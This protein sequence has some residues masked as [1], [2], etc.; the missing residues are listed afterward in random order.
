MLVP[1]DWEKIWKV[2]KWMRFQDDVWECAG[3]SINCT[4][5]PEIRFARVMA[6]AASMGTMCKVCFE[7]KSDV[8]QTL[9]SDVMILEDKEFEVLA[10]MAS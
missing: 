9:K 6:Q 3:W 8:L 1:L 4:G 5:R 10:V 7:E 2:Q